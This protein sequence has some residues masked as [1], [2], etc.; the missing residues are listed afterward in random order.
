VPAELGPVEVRAAGGIVTRAGA[1]GTE[2]LVVHRPA[3]DDW[4]LPKGK[5]DPGEDVE[6]GARREVLEETGVHAVVTGRAGS[7]RY[8]DRHG[9]TKEVHYFTM[10]VHE[11]SPRSPDD[12]V[13][14]VE[15]WPLDTAVTSLTYAHD[16]ALVDDLGS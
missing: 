6:T 12:E 10:A 9:R 15:W 4:S 11:T 1:T 8:D 16:R 3:Y 5:L 14:V 2:I 7:V 13:D